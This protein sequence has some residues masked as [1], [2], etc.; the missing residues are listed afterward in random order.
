MIDLLR[1]WIKCIGLSIQLFFIDV[2]YRI[3]KSKEKKLLK[4]VEGMLE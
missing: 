2:E 4:K 1:M 3:Q